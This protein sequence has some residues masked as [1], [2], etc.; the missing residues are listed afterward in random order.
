MKI[1]DESVRIEDQIMTLD[2]AT[3]ATLDGPVEVLTLGSDFSQLGSLE[4]FQLHANGAYFSVRTGGDLIHG[5]AWALASLLSGA[6]AEIARQ[7]VLY[8]GQAFGDNGMNNAWSRTNNHEKLQRIYEDHVDTDCEIFVAPLSLERKLWTNDDHL[9]SSEQGPDMASYYRSF[10]HQD[11]PHRIRKASVDLVEHSL[12]SYFAPPYNEKLKQWRVSEPTDAMRKMQAAGFRLLHVHLSG[13]WGLARFYSTRELELVRSHFISQDFPPAPHRPVLR[14]IAA[15]QMSGWKVGALLTQHGKEIFAN[16]AEGSG[17]TMRVFGNEAP[18]IR[19]PPGVTLPPRTLTSRELREDDEGFVAQ[20]A[21]RAA[22]REAREKEREANKPLAHPGG[23]TYDPS[24]GT[25]AAGEQN[26]GRRI[27][28]RLHDATT[29]RVNSGL[30]F[31]DPDT[32]KSN[33]LQVL[34]LE[35]GMTGVYFIVPSDPSGRNDFLEKWGHLATSRPIATNVEGTIETLRSACRMIDARGAEGYYTAPSEDVPAVLFGVDDA[36]PVLLDPE[37]ARLVGRIVVEGGERGIGLYMVVSD[38]VALA[39]NPA[40]MRHLVTCD[41]KA[42]FCLDGNFVLADLTARY[43]D[44][45]SQTWRDDGLSFVVH[46]GHNDTT[47]G[48][49]VATTTSDISPADAQSWCDT[50]LS[51]RGAA[52]IGWTVVDSDP[53]SWWTIDALQFDRWFLRRHQDAWTLI[54]VLTNNPALASK[55]GAEVLQ[56]AEAAIEHRFTT[57]IAPW[58]IGPT[59]G[60]QGLSALY[61]DITSDIVVKDRSASLM[62]LLTRLY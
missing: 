6:K 22:V 1:I 24:T 61:A 50:L 57:M 2:F 14:G 45:R 9:D 47:L 28:W 30:I 26:D 7:E 34:L 12:I 40:L 27:R 53:R 46:S 17:V 19:K 60:E 21:I 58:R 3:S 52:T 33:L 36:D 48:L 15:E 39:E 23:S 8:I 54:R 20:D 13:W 43:G 11:D 32:G 49:I 38:L 31:G 5:D 16:L 10:A 37:G 44:S 55:N 25:I 51:A 59:T 56:W 35:A 29:G 18:V 4:D 62:Q 41:Q 42:A